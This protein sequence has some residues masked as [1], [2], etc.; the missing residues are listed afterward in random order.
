[1]RVRRKNT[2]ANATEVT[3][4]MIVT[5]AFP[6]YIKTVNGPRI[7]IRGSFSVVSTD[8]HGLNSEIV[9]PGDWIVEEHDVIFFI[10]NSAF[11][12]VFEEIKDENEEPL[13]L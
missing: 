7:D 4:Q 1:M 11:E 8:E 5:G 12:T 9:R 2:T 10:N 13:S 6:S 3:E